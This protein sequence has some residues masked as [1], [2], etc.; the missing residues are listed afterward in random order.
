MPSLGP[1]V[2]TAIANEESSKDFAC[3][4]RIANQNGDPTDA[5]H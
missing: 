3:E 1:A 5:E 2:G 4:E